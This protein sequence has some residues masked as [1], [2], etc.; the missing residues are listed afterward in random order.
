MVD[1]A[2]GGGLDAVQPGNGARGRV[3][4]AAALRG[5]VQNVRVVEQGADADGHEVLA[6]PE[7]LSGE[8]R[9][10]ASAGGLDDEVRGVEKLLTGA[11]GRRRGER[12]EEVAG[13]RLRAAGDAGDG[14]GQLAGLAGLEEGLADCATSDDANACHNALH[15]F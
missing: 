14:E 13:R 3:E 2:G 12:L 4:P 8:V 5:Q 1:S 7:G 6:G 11:V 15:T 10:D 9:H